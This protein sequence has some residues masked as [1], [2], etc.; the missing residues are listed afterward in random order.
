MCFSANLEAPTQITSIYLFGVVAQLAAE[1]NLLRARAQPDASLKLGGRA[2][3]SAEQNATYLF[4][5]SAIRRRQRRR[6]RPI[7]SHECCKR[8]TTSRAQQSVAY[9][10]FKRTS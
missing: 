3:A 7:K 8:S 4:V 2:H 6:Q 1:L 5:M 10:V 9:D